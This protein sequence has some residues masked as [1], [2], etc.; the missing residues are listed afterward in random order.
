M[1]V[2][3]QLKIEWSDLLSGVWNCLFSP[4]RKKLENDLTQLWAPEGDAI[5]CFSVRSGLD[6]LLQ[7]LNWQEGEEILFSAL[8]VKG[9]VNIV[10]RHGLVPVPIDLDFGTMAPRLD[11]MEQAITTKTR[12]VLVAHLFGAH[13]D[14]DPL[15]EIARRH[16]LII[17]EDCAQCFDGLGYTGH[18]NADIAMFSFG[19]L[20]TATA[21]GGALIRVKDPKLR[22]QMR[23][24]QSTYPVQRHKIYLVRILKFAA[25]KIA[26]T[27]VFL[28][29]IYRM[30]SLLNKDYE[31]AIGN[32]VRGVAKLGN[33]QKLRFQPSA[34]LLAMIM[35]RLK[36]WKGDDLEARTRTAKK[37]LS[38]LGEQVPVPSKDNPV[39]TYW[40]F[41]MVA[42]A[43]KPLIRELRRAGYD[44]ANLPKSQAV[45]PPEDRPELFPAV[46]QDT[47][48]HLVVLPCHP[49][50]SDTDLESQA[51]IIKRFLEK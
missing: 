45:E 31:D 24:L 47:L 21:L 12:A 13:Y 46:A 37:F 38:Y 20:K 8:N 28:S 42:R 32:S 22:T 35:R 23:Q 51:N 36:K 27:R 6:L 40:A 33:A 48:Q 14:L 25:L 11:L 10:K 44:A 2:R 43:P 50:M 16:N 18:K 17:I 39:H 15:I 29:L 41:P 4:D 5:A 34:A 9:M 3:M 1:W 30:F 49:G 26:T 19:P 7:S